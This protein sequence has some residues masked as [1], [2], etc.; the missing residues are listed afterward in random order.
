MIEVKSVTQ[1]ERE[2][3]RQRR[4]IA[5]LFVFG[6]LGLAYAFYDYY[7]IVNHVT[8]P[9]DLE[10]VDPAVASLKASGLVEDFDV[11]QHVITVN[12]GKWSERKRPEKIGI[13]TQLARYCADK[14]KSASWALTVRGHATSATLSELGPKGLV[15][16]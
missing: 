12:E 14:N 9:Q 5:S 11:A 2:D 4:I 10:A 8:I 15:V 1:A 6:I 16:N 3:R 7:Q 13:I